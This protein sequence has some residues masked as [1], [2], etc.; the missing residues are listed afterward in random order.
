VRPSHFRLRLCALAAV[1]GLLLAGCSTGSPQTDAASFLNEH[2]TAARSLVSMT[3]AVGAEVA[4]LTGSP[5]ASQLA[6]IARAAG[7][8]HD[9]ALKDSEWNVPGAGEEGAEEEDVPRAGTQVTE[10]AGELAKA[11]SDLKS[12]TKSPNTAA[13]RHYKGKL[14][15]ARVEWNEG[16]AQLWYLAHRSHAP[17]I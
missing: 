8:A 17:T 7:E 1:G 16:I 6:G 3:R 14:A 4:G 2:A 9:A 12:Y 15:N 5:A 13:L 11:M 10:G